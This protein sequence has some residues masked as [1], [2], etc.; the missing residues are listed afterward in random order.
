MAASE[1]ADFL[2]VVVADY[3]Y[4]L[5]IKAQGSITEEGW[6]NQVVHLADDNSEERITLSTG[7]IFYIAYPINQLSESESGTIFDLY[8]NPVKANGIGRSFYLATYD[9]SGVDYIVRFD[10]KLTRSGNAVTRWGLPGIR[11]RI[12]GKKS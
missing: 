3:N 6:K 12:L 1:V 9:S 11:F 8:H 10:G 5:S 4:T 2:T 7:S